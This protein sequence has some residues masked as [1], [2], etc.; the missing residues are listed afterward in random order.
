MQVVTADNGSKLSE[1]G[2][3]GKKE[4]KKEI[5]IK[6]S[7]AKQALSIGSSVLEIALKFWENVFEFQLFCKNFPSQL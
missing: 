6:I 2:G 4:R 1:L 5:E 3:G 7:I